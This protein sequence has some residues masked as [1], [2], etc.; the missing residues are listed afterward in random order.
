ME[1]EKKRGRSLLKNARD[2]SGDRAANIPFFPYFSTF[3]SFQ[4]F[5]KAYRD[6]V[7]RRCAVKNSGSPAECRRKF[8]F[9]TAFEGGCGG[10]GGRGEEEW[11]WNQRVE[12]FSA[13]AAGWLLSDVVSF[14]IYSPRASPLVKVNNYADAS[15]GR[16]LLFAFLFFF[17]WK[18]SWKFFSFLFSYHNGIFVA[19]VILMDEADN[20]CNIILSNFESEVYLSRISFLTDRGYRN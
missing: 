18:E 11:T 3:F 5:S 8:S 10:G 4:P 20:C 1:R 14:A 6:A 2:C 15:G 19:M 16:A 13:E 12:R 7:Q 9:S 17:F